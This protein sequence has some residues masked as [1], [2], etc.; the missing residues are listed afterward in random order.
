M[1]TAGGG[2]IDVGEARAAG[3]GKGCLVLDRAGSMGGS[4]EA[5][6]GNEPGD[7]ARDGAGLGAGDGAGLEAGD[8]AGVWITM[9]K[10][11]SFWASSGDNSSVCGPSPELGSA[12]EGGTHPGTL[13][14]TGRFASSTA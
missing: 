12:F 4:V 6:P 2:T 14:G 8:G 7:G 13:E 1:T 9:G 3:A 11:L 5:R 10:G